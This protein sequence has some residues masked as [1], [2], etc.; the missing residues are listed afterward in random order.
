MLC[1]QWE[2]GFGCVTVK[3]RGEMGIGVMHVLMG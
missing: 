1:V 3:V 2:G